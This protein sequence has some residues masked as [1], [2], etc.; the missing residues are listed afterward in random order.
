[1]GRLK[2]VGAQDALLLLRASF[3]APR[4]QYL[5]RCSP[6]VDH[7]A[8]TRFDQQL[9]SAISGI[10]NTSLTDTQWLQASLPIR[11][12]GLGIRR[13]AS[14]ALPAYLA[15]AASTLPI[16][17][18]LLIDTTVDK[19]KFLSDY[20][21]QWQVKTGQEVQLDALPVRQV[22]W[23][24]PCVV[25]D[26]ERVQSELVDQTAKARFEAISAPHAGDWLLALP[27]PTCGLQLDDEAVRVAVSLRL[28]V[29][30]GA[31]HT[32]R[33]GAEVDCRGL[34]SLVCKKAPGRIMRHQ[35]LNDLVKRA[36]TSV[37]V[38]ATKEPVGLLRSDGRRPDGMSLIPWCEGKMVV[39]DVTVAT[40][41]AQSY[42]D[43]AARGAGVVAEQ[44]ATRK[45]DKYA[46][47]ARS[48][49]FLPLAFENLG[50]M[51][52]EAVEFFKEVGRR[53]TE[54]SMDKR[55]AFFLFQRVSVM[56]QRFNSVLFRDS[57]CLDD[58]G[59]DQ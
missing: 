38:P 17:S 53:L 19:D 2:L 37:G 14:L 7:P 56:L 41:L 30:L 16:Q 5:M 51:N 34:H 1:M 48:Y 52:A 20:I 42:V 25:L 35:Q 57:F 32:C 33:C 39:W 26:R 22:S 24:Q 50:P 11:M 49:L 27:L 15:S 45:R 18:S 46:E 40:T 36:L 3:S 13:V 44:A 10:T 31:A 59:P 29:N 6:S 54:D 4:V 12:G 58:I 21:A 47:L 43:D 55:E 23:D 28:G 8:L 9:R